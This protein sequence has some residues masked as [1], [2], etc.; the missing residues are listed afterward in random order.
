MNIFKILVKEKLYF[1]HEKDGLSQNYFYS[2][3][4]S[5]VKDRYN[6]SQ[7]IV[8]INEIEYGFFEK[9]GRIHNKEKIDDDIIEKIINED[10]KNKQNI[11]EPETM[12]E[13]TLQQQNLLRNNGRVSDIIINYLN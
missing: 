5:A 6:D 12:F 4:R 8:D 11:K 9:Y 10:T 13:I 7:G 2:S 1:L 3:L